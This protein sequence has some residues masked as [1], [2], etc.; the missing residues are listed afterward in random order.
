MPIHVETDVSV[1]RFA[2]TQDEGGR[3]LT[4]PRAETKRIEGRAGAVSYGADECLF[5]N[6]AGRLDMLRWTA[7]HTSI[8]SAWLR[9]DNGR[10]DISVN[11]IELPDEVMLTRAEQGLGPSPTS[12]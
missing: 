9:D 5:D 4:F 10:F 2:F 11:R 6:L 1:Q 3:R 12:P 8:G 7:D